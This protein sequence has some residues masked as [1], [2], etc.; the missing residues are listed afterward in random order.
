[1]KLFS[2]INFFKKIKM[3]IIINF[4]PVIVSAIIF[5]VILLVSVTSN[6][7]LKEQMTNTYYQSALNKLDK[8]KTE[9]EVQKSSIKNLCLQISFNDEIHKLFLQNPNALTVNYVSN[10]LKSYAS[11]VDGINSIN[12]FDGKKKILYTPGGEYE[13]DS[14][15]G[16][17]F[18]AYSEHIPYALKEFHIPAKDGVENKLIY[19]YTLEDTNN[20]IIIDIDSEKFY[21]NF[22]NYHIENN[23]HI[24]ITNKQNKTIYT[25]DDSIQIEKIPNTN[26]YKLIKHNGTEYM[27]FSVSS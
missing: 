6:F 1:M 2:K 19:S 25:T 26:N 7:Q 11:F 14:Y 12:I 5:A 3:N 22:T 18:D 8:L 27:F 24:L 20:L 15:S 4:L 21:N 9:N 16:I 23:S 13:A 17:N 10:H